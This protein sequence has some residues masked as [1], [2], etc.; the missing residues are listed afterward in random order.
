MPEHKKLVSA[1]GHLPFLVFGRRYLA[2]AGRRVIVRVFGVTCR[3]Y[4]A[5]LRYTCISHPH[6]LCGRVYCSRA[7][8]TLAACGVAPQRLLMFKRPSRSESRW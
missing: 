3:R 5:Y 2:G 4:F 6:L 8:A 7:A 1:G